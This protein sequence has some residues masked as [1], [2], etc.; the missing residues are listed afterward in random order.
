MKNLI[1][2]SLNPAMLVE[3]LPQA[4]AAQYERTDTRK[5]HRNGYKDRSLKTRYGETTLW[6]PQFPEF[7]FETQ[8]FGRHEPAPPPVV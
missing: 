2:W 8:V 3:A 1:T 7:P 4:R 6:K 5:T